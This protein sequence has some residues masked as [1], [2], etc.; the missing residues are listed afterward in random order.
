MWYCGEA[1][2]D[3]GAKEATVFGKRGTI[4]GIVL[5]TMGGIKGVQEIKRQRI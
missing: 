2:P 1:T 5:R 4:E 3:M